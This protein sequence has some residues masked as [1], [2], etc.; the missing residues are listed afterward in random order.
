MDFLSNMGHYRFLNDLKN[1]EKES[2]YKLNDR[3]ADSLNFTKVTNESNWTCHSSLIS[4]EKFKWQCLNKS[5]SD[6][7]NNEEMDAD[8]NMMHNEE[9]NR[10]IS[11]QKPS[12]FFSN[13]SDSD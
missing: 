5:I 4:R 3:F 9:F 7:D 8:K 10:G 2:I 12:Q 13:D 11:S 6:P 1:F